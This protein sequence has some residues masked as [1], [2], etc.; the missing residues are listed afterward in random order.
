MW[1]LMEWKLTK[2]VAIVQR[3]VRTIIAAVKKWM[4]YVHLFV[5][6]LL[7][8]I[9][10]SSFLKKRFKNFTSHVLGRRIK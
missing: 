7:A 2:K 10:K 1:L 5:D 8:K 3:T 6:V 9:I 4:V